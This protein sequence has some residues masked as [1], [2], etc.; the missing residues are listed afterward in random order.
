MREFEM[1]LPDILLVVTVPH[2]APIYWP[3]E[4]NCLGRD[5]ARPPGGDGGE[6]DSCHPILIQNHIEF[7]L[8]NLSL[9]NDP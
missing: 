3:D 7:C 8:N 1:I 2:L 4:L 9:E 5:I 6:L